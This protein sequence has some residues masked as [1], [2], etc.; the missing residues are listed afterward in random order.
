LCA[1]SCHGPA[2]LL[3]ALLWPSQLP[4]LVAHAA[5]HERLLPSGA[6]FRVASA[7]ARTRVRLCG[8]P[9]VDLSGRL[10]LMLGPGLLR[11]ALHR[12]GRQVCGQMSKFLERA[13]RSD[14]APED[15]PRLAHSGGDELAIVNFRCDTLMKKDC[16]L[17]PMLP[18]PF[19]STARLSQGRR[20]RWRF[21]R[22]RVFSPLIF[23]F[24]NMPP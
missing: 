14:R 4:A 22:S 10:F 23:E 24:S 20:S 17:S 21:D 8:P 7:R 12:I 2:S 9:G 11:S 15:D 16:C 3:Q 5:S 13:I 18:R 6:R 1:P 19:S